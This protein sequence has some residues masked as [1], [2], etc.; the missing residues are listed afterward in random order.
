M[1]ITKGVYGVP[2]TLRDIIE[3]GLTVMTI[4]RTVPARP[5]QYIYRCAE[6]G[7]KLYSPQIMFNVRTVCVVCAAEDALK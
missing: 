2:P 7:V 1:T 4:P 5:V 3:T 6:C